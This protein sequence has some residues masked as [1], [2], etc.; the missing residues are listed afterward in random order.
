MGL[1]GQ[2]VVTGRQLQGHAVAVASVA[3]ASMATGLILL[4][5]WER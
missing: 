2:P 1:F 4:V 5:L 3:V